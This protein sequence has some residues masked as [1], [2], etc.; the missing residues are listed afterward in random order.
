MSFPGFS[1]EVDGTGSKGNYI[2]SKNNT[3]PYSK[4]SKGNN[5]RYS[6][7]DGRQDIILQ[8]QGLA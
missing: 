6:A 4:I 7:A 5:L 8:T 3:G 2:L 1:S